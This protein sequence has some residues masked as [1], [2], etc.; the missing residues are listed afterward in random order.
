MTE[1][2]FDEAVN[3]LTGIIAIAER[4]NTE[5]SPIIVQLAL[6]V[7]RLLESQRGGK[8]DC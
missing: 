2:D 4:A 5:Y 3:C 6:Q 7:D 1:K 8:D